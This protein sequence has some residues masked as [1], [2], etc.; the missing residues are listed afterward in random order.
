[1]M[2]EDHEHVENSEGRGRHDEEVNRD[3][4]GEVILEERAPGLRGR[5]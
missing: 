1:M 2:L 3:E 5:L 4:V